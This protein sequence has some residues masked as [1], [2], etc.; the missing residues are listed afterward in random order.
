MS[1]LPVRVKFRPTDKKTP[2]IRRKKRNRS[3]GFLGIKSYDL[4][5]GI[6]M[7][8]NSSEPNRSVKHK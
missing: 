2:P 1:Q 3:N 6:I 7:N 8:K 4:R 5:V